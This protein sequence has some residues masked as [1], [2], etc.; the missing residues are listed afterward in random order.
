MNSVLKRFGE[1][2]IIPVVVLEDAKDAKPLG[3]ALVEG[4]LPVYEFL[5][6]GKGFI[7][8]IRE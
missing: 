4:G 5:T 8:F 6:S 7:I 1:I 3:K 2:G